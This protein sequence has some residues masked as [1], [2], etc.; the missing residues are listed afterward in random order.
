MTEA[1]DDRPL[2]DSPSPDDRF[3]LGSEQYRAAG[4]P[5]A[6]LPQ[7]HAVC[8][9]SAAAL[10][11]VERFVRDL[12]MNGLA[13]R[14]VAAYRSYL[15]ALQADCGGQ[16]ASTLDEDQLRD[17]LAALVPVRNYQPASIKVA[18]AAI[19]K[20]YRL[21]CPREWKT[22]R[23]MRV[24]AHSPLP[25]VLSRNEVSRLLGEVRREE[26]RVCLWTI[27]SLGLRLSEGVNLQVQDI[28]LDRGVVHV[29]R[30][31]GARDRIV[32]LPDGTLQLLRDYW[33]THR[34]DTFLFPAGGR[35]TPGRRHATATEPIPKATIQGVWKRV[36]DHSH[37]GRKIC[38]HTLRHSYA[39][40]LLEAGVNI[41]LVQQ[42]LGHTTLQHTIKYLHLT[43]QGQ[44][45]A[46]ARINEIMV[47][48]ELE[49]GVS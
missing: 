5:E 7:R 3:T 35:G 10:A 27:Y 43:R 46:V 4:G 16:A 12:R 6:N 41:R 2:D 17:W 21:T 25:E 15:R 28:R 19:R 14:T 38:V 26:Y 40:H 32:P 20:F 44:E 23:D 22:L 39:T 47:P 9:P 1:F 34:H 45:T 42:Y 8:G 24:P 48:P 33:K 36:V 30:G 37:I 29:H 31:K 13:D 49:G 11:D 18:H